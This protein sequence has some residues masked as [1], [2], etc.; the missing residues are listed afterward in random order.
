[1]KIIAGTGNI[2]VN[3]KNL[4]DFVQGNLFCDF[5]FFITSKLS[6]FMFLEQLGEI[7]LF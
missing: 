3:G 7:S 6:V 2:V 5:K 4:T 1:M